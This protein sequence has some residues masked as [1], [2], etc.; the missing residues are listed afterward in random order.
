MEIKEIINK[1][2][3]QPQ[4]QV[5]QYELQPQ[6]QPQLQTEQYDLQYGQIQ[7]DILIT[8]GTLWYKYICQQFNFVLSEQQYL[9]LPFPNQQYVVSLIC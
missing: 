5:E 2:K 9:F 1:T 6:L 4:L 7:F 8:R 3:E